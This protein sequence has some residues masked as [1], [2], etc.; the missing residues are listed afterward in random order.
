MRCPVC[1]G[2]GRI[3]L[4]MFMA[5]KELVYPRYYDNMIY[6]MTC[7]DGTNINSRFDGTG[8]L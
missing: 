3:D 4:G 7:W 6:I 2:K 1:F 5:L 8:I